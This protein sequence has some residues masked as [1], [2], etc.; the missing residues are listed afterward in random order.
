MFY[1]SNTVRISQ[2]SI[3]LSSKNT[4]FNP[5]KVQLFPSL[6]SELNLPFFPSK[7][8]NAFL[9]QRISSINAVSAICEATGADVREVSRAISKDSRIGPHFLQASLGFGG[10]C[11]KKDI[12]NLV[13]RRRDCAPHVILLWSGTI[14]LI[15]CIIRA[16]YSVSA[17]TR[18]NE[19][20]WKF[21]FRYP[22]K[23]SLE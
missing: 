22:Q 14:K 7:A 6:Y 13:S 1:L 23:I 11:F 5:W 16:S 15:V 21:A 18:I 3:S 4:N 12:L 19:F 10:S 8:A 9:A 20:G 17:S 2:V